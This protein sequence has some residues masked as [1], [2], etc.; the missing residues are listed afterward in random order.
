MNVRFDSSDD[1]SVVIRSEAI[2][3]EPKLTYSVCISRPYHPRCHIMVP[4]RDNNALLYCSWLTQKVPT[5]CM[6]SSLNTL[7][8]STRLFSGREPMDCA[9]HHLSLH[10]RH[11]ETLQDAPFELHTRHQRRIALFHSLVQSVTVL[12]ARVQ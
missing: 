2:D 3:M 5:A 9:E 12:D 7:D 6:F 11:C 10:I 4:E 8:I 1:V